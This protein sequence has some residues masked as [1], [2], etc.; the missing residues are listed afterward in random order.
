MKIPLL[1]CCLFAALTGKA[2]LQLGGAAPDAK[3]LPGAP[4]APGG[5]EGIY[6]PNLFEGTATVNIP[7][8][9]YKAEGMDLGISLSYNTLGVKLDELASAAGSH[10]EILGQPGIYRTV[11]GLPDEV[12]LD[13]DTIYQNAATFYTKVKGRLA[14]TLETAQQAADQKV[15]RDQECD[16][17]TLSAGGLSFSFRIGRTGLIFTHPHN[18]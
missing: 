17:F 5:M 16:E 13:I 7:I 9:Q 3:M 8:Y 15:F 1:L 2:Q 18:N 10:W 4:A 12:A 6:S 11:H 14:Q